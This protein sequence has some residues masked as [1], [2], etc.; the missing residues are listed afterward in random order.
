ML[1]FLS[2]FVLSSPPELQDGF[3]VSTRKATDSE[4]E[5][6]ITRIFASF[7]CTW[8]QRGNGFKYDSYNGF[9]TLIGYKTDKV[10]DFC[11]KNR[12][13]KACDINIKLGTQKEHDCR[14]NH[15]GTAKSMEAEGAI[16][17][18]TKSE[19]LKSANVEVGVFIGDNDSSVLSA[20]EE[21]VDYQIV[22]QSDINHSKKGVSNFCTK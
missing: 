8:C 5:R 20:L 10:L 17:L 15:F 7:D 19:I 2:T 12:K 3:I 22:K 11:T 1:F 16:Q 4:P 6:N 9:C 13:C 18:V 14:L 21:V